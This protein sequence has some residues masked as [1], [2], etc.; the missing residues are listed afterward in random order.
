MLVQLAQPA[1]F[2]GFT[3]CEEFP[4]DLRRRLG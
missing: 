4:L 3:D 1:A 2:V